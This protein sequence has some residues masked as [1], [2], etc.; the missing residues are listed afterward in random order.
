M[1]EMSFEI[2]PNG[3]IPF[4]SAQFMQIPGI[5]IATRKQAKWRPEFVA[6]NDNA[7]SGSRNR[8]VSMQIIRAL[9]RSEMTF[10]FS[11]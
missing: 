4:I 7:N 2:I 3:I 11:C 9:S 10:P 8:V 5:L 6:E 1:L